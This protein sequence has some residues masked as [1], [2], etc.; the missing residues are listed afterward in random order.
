MEDALQAW[1]EASKARVKAQL[2]KAERLRERSVEASSA[3]DTSSDYSIAKCVYALND[4]ESVSD[5]IYV[6]TM[7]KFTNST[8]KELFMSIPLDRKKAW[9][10]RLV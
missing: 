1:T 5:D 6:K 7:E 10:D 2:A 4:F 9:L 8:W 3:R